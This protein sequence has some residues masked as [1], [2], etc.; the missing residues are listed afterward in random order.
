L[1]IVAPLFLWLPMGFVSALMLALCPLAVSSF[2][3][4]N[5]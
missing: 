1:T 5:S 3:Q 2:T 4:L